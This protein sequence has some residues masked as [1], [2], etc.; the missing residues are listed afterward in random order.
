M[1]VLV[2]FTVVQPDEQKSLEAQNTM[3]RN[4]L[5]RILEQGLAESARNHGAD[6]FTV[7]QPDEQKSLDEA[8]NKRNY[9]LADPSELI[10]RAMVNPDGPE[11]DDL[12]H[13]RPLGALY[14]PRR[15]RYLPAPFIFHYNH[16]GL[17]CLDVDF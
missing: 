2:G 9:T 11:I 3:K 8:Q 5:V 14:T 7:V 4:I 15:H 10:C 17:E 1:V 13:Q 6:G 16:Y 12:N